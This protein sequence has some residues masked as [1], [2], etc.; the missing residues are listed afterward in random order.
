MMMMML[1]MIGRWQS[2]VI[3]ASANQSAA[4]PRWL[5]HCCSIAE[6]SEQITL[7]WDL[8]SDI[9]AER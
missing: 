9:W 6:S 1:M 3:A 4:V 2:Y 8:V 5:I 7:I